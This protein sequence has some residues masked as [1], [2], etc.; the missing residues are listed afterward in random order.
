[1][2]G[3]L[4]FGVLYYGVSYLKINAYYLRTS[5]DEQRITRNKKLSLPMRFLW[6]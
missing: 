3:V 5:S 1:M 2:I 4:Y 6:Q